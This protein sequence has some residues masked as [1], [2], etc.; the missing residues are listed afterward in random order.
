MINTAAVCWSQRG[1]GF[2]CSSANGRRIQCSPS[3]L[4]LGSN[5]HNSSLQDGNASLPHESQ[6]RYIPIHHS[7]LHILI[8]HLLH[9]RHT[10]SCS[11]HWHWTWTGRCWISLTAFPCTHFYIDFNLHIIKPE[12]KSWKFKRKLEYCKNI[13][14][15]DWGGK[16][17]VLIKT[18]CGN[19]NRLS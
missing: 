13:S 1:Q 8:V 16:V 5:F 15:L 7:D 4:N 3:N 2:C 12:W 17:G 18:K 10:A 6:R 11:E 9:T 14:T 19:G